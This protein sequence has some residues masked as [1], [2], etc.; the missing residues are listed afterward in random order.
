MGI[1]IVLPNSSGDCGITAGYGTK[2]YNDEGQEIDDITAI[3]IRIRPDSVVEA[4][5]E[6]AVNNKQ[7]MD[8]VHALLGTK[9]LED[10]LKLHGLEVRRIHKLKK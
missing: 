1:K 3:D 9:T 2:V 4:T 6:V 7:E 5:V 10:I 8:N